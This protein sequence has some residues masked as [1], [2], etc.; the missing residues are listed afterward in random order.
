MLFLTNSFCLEFLEVFIISF[1]VGLPFYDMIILAKI[2][3]FNDIQSHNNG[4]KDKLNI[5]PKQLSLSVNCSERVKKSN[6][7]L[8]M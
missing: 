5:S 6:R 7:K 4:L 1:F 3:F 8:S 2:Q